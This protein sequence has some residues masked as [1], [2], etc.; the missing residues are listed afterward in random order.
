MQYTYTYNPFKDKRNDRHTEKDVLMKC[1]QYGYEEEV[2]RW[3]IDESFPN[4]P[5]KIY[6]ALP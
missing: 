1:T 4:E 6:D 2:P 5:E 3:L